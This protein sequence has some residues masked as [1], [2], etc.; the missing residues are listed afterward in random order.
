[1]SVV[2][3]VFPNA[4]KVSQEAIEEVIN[5]THTCTCIPHIIHPLLLIGGKIAEKS[6]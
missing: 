2:L 6:N 1:M 4:P 3:V 5:H